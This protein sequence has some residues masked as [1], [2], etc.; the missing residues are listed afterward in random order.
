VGSPQVGDPTQ[1]TGYYAL[2]GSCH[3]PAG[4]IPPAGAGAGVPAERIPRVTPAP[5]NLARES[6]G[7]KN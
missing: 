7:K 5:P 2:L 6:E 4:K 1:V 3:G